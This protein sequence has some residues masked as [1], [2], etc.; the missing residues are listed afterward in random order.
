MHGNVRQWCSDYYAKQ[1]DLKNLKDPTGPATGTTQVLRGGSWD[2]F[3]KNCRSA[4]R[5]SF[6][7]TSRSGYTG[8]RVVMVPRGR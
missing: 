3:P 1:Y 4:Y 2:D 6:S 5:D 7:Q 8:F